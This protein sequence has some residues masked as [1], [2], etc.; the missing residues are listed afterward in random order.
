MRSVTLGIL[1]L[2]GSGETA[3]SMTKVHRQILKS[4]T[5]VR[6]VSLDTP[7]GFQA[8]VP[9]MTEKI[10]DYFS[11]SLHVDIKPVS[12]LN[13]ADASDV[14]RAV[15]RQE[16]QAANYVFSGPGSPSYA[17]HQWRPVGLADELKSILTQGGVVC[18]ASAAALT[19]GTLTVP[20]YE[21]YKVG[22]SVHWLDGMDVLSLAGIE[23]AIIPHF[24]NAEGGNYD[25]RY[26]YLGRDRLEALERQLP[27][28]VGVL[29][30][31]EHTAALID[32][33]RQTLSVAGKGNVCW[34]LDGD[35]LVFASGTTVELAT[36]RSFEPTTVVER[37]TV[38]E[39]TGVDELV[40][41]AS[42]GGDV[43]A[44]AIA[45]L[46]RMAVTGG[47]GYIDPSSLVAG[48]LEIRESARANRD[49]QLGDRIRDL[50]IDSGIEVMD[51]PDGTTW[52]IK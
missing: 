42:E 7:Y 19:L 3:P 49:F 4:I 36:I 29:G 10:V 9:Q 35:E 33:E 27:D 30:V 50:L 39:P 5:D 52:Q 47:D 24:D 28:G 14:A 32:L 38:E 43:G 12:F 13:F 18:F 20:V 31:D 17:V 46:A 6:A 44:D 34:R 16:V 48:L 51:G 1:A 11:T 2:M 45:T 40:A 41:R 8:N 22:A 21:I 25:T 23:A 37:V 15:F 26:C